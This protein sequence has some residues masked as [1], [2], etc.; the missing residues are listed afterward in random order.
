MVMDTIIWTD[1]ELTKEMFFIN[2]WYSFHRS[3]ILNMFVKKPTEQRV[4]RYNMWFFF[5]LYKTMRKKNDNNT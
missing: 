5:H 1:L 4:L 2:H 3:F